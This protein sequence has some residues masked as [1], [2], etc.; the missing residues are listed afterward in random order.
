MLDIKNRSDRITNI[1][2]SL[3]KISILSKNSL[4]VEAKEEKMR[5]RKQSLREADMSESIL[6]MRKFSEEDEEE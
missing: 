4:Q 5:S 6:L 2:T 1:R 3:K